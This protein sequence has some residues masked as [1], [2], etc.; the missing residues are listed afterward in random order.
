MLTPS[1]NFAYNHDP[2]PGPPGRG[3]GGG[4][5]GGSR[6]SAFEASLLTT[7][8][9]QWPPYTEAKVSLRL[10]PNNVSRIT[11]DFRPQMSVWNEEDVARASAF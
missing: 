5:G 6:N 2:N 3:G 10:N 1:I 4:G 8:L 7:A 9:P 11:D